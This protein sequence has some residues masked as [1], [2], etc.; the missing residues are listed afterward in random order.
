MSET[1]V[2]TEDVVAYKMTKVDVTLNELKELAESDAKTA[3][4]NTDAASKK[5]RD[6]IE[7]TVKR[8]PVVKKLAS[9]QDDLRGIF[10]LEFKIDTRNMFDNLNKI[11]KKKEFSVGVTLYPA[12]R[13]TDRMMFFFHT[14]TGVM[15]NGEVVIKPTAK[16]VTLTKEYIKAEKVKADADEHAR[17]IRI[18]IQDMPTLERHVKGRV[19][20]INLSSTEDGKKIMA[21]IDAMDLIGVPSIKALLE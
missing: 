6:E 16:M 1:A 14:P 17:N 12:D 20:E 15:G 10:G 2:K 8:M 13:H 4:K 11:S 7:A 3:E 21:E 9:L 18:A 5:L 19:A